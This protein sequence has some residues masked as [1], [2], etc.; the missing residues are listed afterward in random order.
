MPKL[1][2]IS[3]KKLIRILEGIGFYRGRSRG[4]HLI[5]INADGRRTVVP[6]HGRDIPSGTLLAI[7]KDL[8]L[9]KEDLARL[10]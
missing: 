9:S 7:L 3:A 10:L 5:M 8:N 4:S 6:M 2:V 1:P